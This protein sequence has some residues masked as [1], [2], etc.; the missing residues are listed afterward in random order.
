MKFEQMQ[1]VMPIG[2]REDILDLWT[3]AS[4]NPDRDIPKTDEAKWNRWR[5]Q[6]EELLP[7]AA[8]LWASITE[9]TPTS[10]VE[11]LLNGAAEFPA[12][13]GLPWMET[14]TYYPWS[15]ELAEAIDRAERWLSEP[16]QEVAAS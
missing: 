1:D 12:W 9:M 16:S 14:L 4:S 5:A 2:A 6:M 7:R 8:E 11:D 13:H 3:W 10:T 15:A